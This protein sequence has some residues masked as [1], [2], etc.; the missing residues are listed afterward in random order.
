MQVRPRAGAA[1]LDTSQRAASLG[2]VV[3]DPSTV[4]VGALR[5]QAFTTL[6]AIGAT[7]SGAGS[8]TM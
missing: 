4:M 6:E 5:I 1:T 3:G 2:A 7:A 8:S